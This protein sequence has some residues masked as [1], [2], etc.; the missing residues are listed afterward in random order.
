MIKWYGCP[1]CKGKSLREFPHGLKIRRHCFNCHFERIEVK[2]KMKTALIII[3]I[4]LIIG[5][6]AFIAFCRWFVGNILGPGSG[7]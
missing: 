1:K 2:S 3:G 6:P 5:I 4:A 7:K